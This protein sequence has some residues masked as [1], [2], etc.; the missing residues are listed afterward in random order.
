MFAAWCHQASRELMN[1]DQSF[2]AVTDLVRVRRAMMEKHH[3]AERL[4][5]QTEAAA[6][7]SHRDQEA[8]YRGRLSTDR[9]SYSRGL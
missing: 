8:L 5:L 6:S 3:R 2:R 7:A 1:S 9:N 4:R